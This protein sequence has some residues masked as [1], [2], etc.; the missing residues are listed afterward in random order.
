MP[1]RPGPPAM[2]TWAD[3]IDAMI[4]RLYPPDSANES[5]RKALHHQASATST[6][7]RLAGEFTAAFGRPA[8][9]ELVLH[10]IPDT[11]FGP[12][13]LHQL[14]LELPWADILT[15][16]YD[17]ILERA[18]AG[19]LGQRYSTVRTP[20]EIVTAIR[21]RIVKL[22]GSFPSIRPFIL[23]EEDFRT[24]P[25]RF[26]PFVNLAQ[27]VAME[28]ILCLIGFTGDDPNFL[29][30]TGWVRDN[31]GAYAPKIYLSGL[32]DLS[33][34]QRLLL[35]GR[36]VTA[37][38]FTPLFPIEA[39]PDLRTRHQM[40]LE[41]FLKSLANGRPYDVF[42]WPYCPPT[43]GESASHLPE[44]LP[45]IMGTEPLHENWDPQ[46]VSEQHA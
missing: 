29:Y 23:T 12:S 11:D 16:N 27:Q 46:S 45:R 17:T 3:L 7:L 37:I 5:R 9:D 39:Y 44:L 4:D 20:E 35:H 21:P 43:R 40:A 10:A 26:A 24:Y 2:P 22:H 36:N 33:D 42:D 18:A 15:T 38:D 41:W 1:V 14:L 6:A 8:L 25:R 30:W 31:L 32:L 13:Q 28:N 34:S 19:I